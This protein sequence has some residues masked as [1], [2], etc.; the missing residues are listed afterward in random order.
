MAEIHRLKNR[1][2]KGAKVADKDKVSVITVSY[3]AE[4]TI[5]KTIE[6][7]LYQTYPYIEYIIIDGASTDTTYGVICEYD[8]KFKKR[9]IPY[10]H[11]SEPDNGIYDAMNKALDYCTG[12]WVNYMNAADCFFQDT[13]LEE[14]FIKEQRDDISCIY[15]N[16]WIVQ[17]DRKYFRR[18][19]QMDVIYFRNPII[20]QSAFVR[21]NI[22]CKYKFDTH[23]EIVAD[24]DFFLKIYLDGEKF[25]RIDCDIV[26]FDVWGASHKEWKKTS[27]ECKEIQKRS[28][29]NNCCRARR[30][31]RNNIISPLKANKVIFTIYFFGME[32]RRK[33][34]IWENL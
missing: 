20:H 33:I 19:G 9:G 5:R 26:L 28:G 7:V 24:Y 31:V 29:V 18:A 6:S 13:T 2:G 1:I 34:R 4:S 32:L 14:V 15:G 17:G 21:N 16:A 22:L 8:E 11:I 10:I 23:Y 25:E 30:F 12:E 27:K 3:N